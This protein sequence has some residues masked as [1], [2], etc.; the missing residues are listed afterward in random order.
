M[1]NRAFQVLQFATGDI[2]WKLANIVLLAVAA[3]VLPQDEA[4]LVV[5]SQTASM[6][7]LS[8]G[9]LGFRSA[10]IRL[11]AVDSSQ[12]RV[13]RR[14]VFRKRLVSVLLI[15]LPAALICAGV[16][17]DNLRAFL[18][19]ALIV[20]AYL[21]YFA[22]S[23]WVLL[24]SG[25]PGAAGAAR[26]V[27]AVILLLLSGL[28]SISGA[29]ITQFALIIASGYGGFALVSALMLR[30]SA[31]LPLVT[32]QEGA[33]VIKGELRWGASVALAVAFTFNTLF[34]SIEILLAGAF[35]GE[36]A[37]TAFAAPFRLVFSIY[38]MG[39][40]LAQYF[41]PY[42]ARYSAANGD[43]PRYWLLYVFGFLLVGTA[44]AV[45]TYC[46]ASWLI[47][48]V[49]NDAFSQAGAMLQALAPTVALDA[50]VACLGTLLVMQNKGK[51]VAVTIGLA[52]LT[53]A[54]IF[55]LTKDIGLHSILYAKYAA[56]LTL[57][58]TQLCFLG[59]G[60]AKHNTDKV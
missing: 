55:F 48:I 59:F 36:S 1:I 28:V 20:L 9:D 60:N 22:A 37:S 24:A 58:T 31:P 10:G 4:A 47:R 5:L 8:L 45:V 57:V 34:H 18:G 43:S 23:D 51:T 15:G 25:R 16:L 26:M 40:I 42:F 49:Y 41:S 32:G 52:C 14:E 33:N 39:W 56:Y 13:I 53:S 29:T 30:N 17:T 2:L 6:V 3:R 12:T 44:T 46:S 54:I 35:L 11:V 19:L 7:L 21:P 38:A 50:V 27:Y